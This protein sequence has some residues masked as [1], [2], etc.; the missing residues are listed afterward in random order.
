MPHDGSSTCRGEYNLSGA[1]QIWRAGEKRLGQ[2]LDAAA[3]RSGN[4]AGGG[5]PSVS[6][7]AAFELYDTYGFPLEITQELA[8]ERGVQARCAVLCCACMHAV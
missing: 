4:G 5:P 7:A 6:G 8:A 2:V 1:C 3:A